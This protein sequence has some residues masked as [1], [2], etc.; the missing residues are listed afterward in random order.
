MALSSE[1]L[2]QFRS[3]VFSVQRIGLAWE[4]A[5]NTNP[6][7]FTAEIIRYAEEMFMANEKSLVT[8]DKTLD[9]LETFDLSGRCIHQYIIRLVKFFY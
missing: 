4:K 6:R 9:K 8:I 7:D 2:P 3:K 1:F 5:Y